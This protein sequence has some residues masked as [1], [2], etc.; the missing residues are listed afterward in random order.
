MDKLC[1]KCELLHRLYSI[2]YMSLFFGF[3]EHAIIAIKF[4]IAH[5]LCV[6]SGFLSHYSAL[7]CPRKML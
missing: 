6:S 3:I 4:W 2:L 5:I 1:V 7:L